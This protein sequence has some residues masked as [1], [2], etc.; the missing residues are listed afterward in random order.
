MVFDPRPGRVG[1]LA[2]GKAR[3][4]A[5]CPTILSKDGMPALALGALAGPPSRWAYCRLF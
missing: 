1:S 2:P 3:F 5:M 4:A